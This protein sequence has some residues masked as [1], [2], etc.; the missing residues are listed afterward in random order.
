MEDPFFPGYLMQ[1]FLKSW[2]RDVKESMA[3]VT[4]ECDLAEESFYVAGPGQ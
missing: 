2:M 3:Y 1:F 4:G